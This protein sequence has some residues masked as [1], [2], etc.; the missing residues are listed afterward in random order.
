MCKFL[1]ALNLEKKNSENAEAFSFTLRLAYLVG[2]FFLRTILWMQSLP[3]ESDC[4]LDLEF[5]VLIF[6]AKLILGF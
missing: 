2:P 4:G 3:S 1:E 5:S 6:D